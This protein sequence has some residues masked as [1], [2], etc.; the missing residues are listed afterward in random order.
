[1]YREI[2]QYPAFLDALPGG[3]REWC[4][5]IVETLL[6][7]EIDVRSLYIDLFQQAL[8]EIGELWSRNIISVD[9]EHYATAIIESLFP[10]VYPKIF[11]ADHIGRKAMISCLANEYHQ[12]GCKMVADTLEMAGWDT[13]FLGANTTTEELKS[14]IKS[15]HPDLLA[16]SLSMYHNLSGLTEAVRGIRYDFQDL[17]IVTGG[18]GFRFAGDGLFAD[19]PGVT[20]VRSLYDLEEFIEGFI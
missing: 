16:L 10:L 19:I 20:L 4:H 14:E 18:Y 1:M 3:Y 13:L 5:G 17:P 6:Q 2:E 12:L 11:T 7:S 15:E 9:V 8:Y